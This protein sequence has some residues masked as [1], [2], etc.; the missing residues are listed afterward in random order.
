[1]K[2]FNHF[3]SCPPAVF[4]LFVLACPGC[5]KDPESALYTQNDAYKNAVQVICTGV[6]TGINTWAAEKVTDSLGLVEL[7][8]DFTHEAFFFNDRTGF[9]FIETLGGYNVAH[10]SQPGLEGTLT[11]DQVDVD[12]RKIVRDMISLATYTGFGFLEYR[13]TN[14]VTQVVGNKTGFVKLIPEMDWYAGSSFYHID[15]QALIAPSEVSKFAVKNA[16]RAMA[17]GLGAVLEKHTG[18]SLHGV[19]LMR[20]FLRNIRFF[21]DMSGY[22]YVIDFRGYN[23]VQP[24]APKIQGTYEYDLKDSKGTYLVRELIDA[25]KKGG[26]Y[27][28]Y[29]WMNYSLN[30]EVM[31]KAYTEQIPGQDYLIGSG[32]Y[33]N[34]Q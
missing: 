13:Y 16:V 28:E 6:G 25:A 8:R 10:P 12:G 17:L 34:N 5:S 15:G 33:L 27:V 20:S 19:E 31:K 21:D 1:M 22:F 29:Y 23:V 30:R 32:V 7:T 4:V 2:K 26:G 18:D 9:V 11:I 3:L 24:P 14:P